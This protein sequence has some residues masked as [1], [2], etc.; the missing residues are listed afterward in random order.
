VPSLLLTPGE[1]AELL[2]V[3]KGTIL[4]WVKAWEQGEPV[5][6]G[7]YIPIRV[8]NANN[9]YGGWV[10]FVPAPEDEKPKW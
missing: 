10:R 6:F 9:K 8:G 2:G 4:R 5:N 3:T 7:G 1:M